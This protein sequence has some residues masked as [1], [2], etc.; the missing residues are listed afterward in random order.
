M[1]TDFVDIQLSDDVIDD[2][3][4]GHGGGADDAVIKVLREV[5]QH[6]RL[7]ERVDISARHL[8]FLPEPFGKIHAL[9]FLDVS[10]NQLQVCIDSLEISI[11]LL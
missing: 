5:F 2:R 4:K 10:H 9:V 6:R 7:V 3:E 11:P 1:E 8:K